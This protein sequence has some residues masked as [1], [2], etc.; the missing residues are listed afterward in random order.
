MPWTVSA[1]YTASVVGAPT[2]AYAPWAVFCCAG[3]LFTLV[4]AAA[5]EKMG[6]GLN[7]V[8]LRAA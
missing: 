4:L 5:F 1:V 7:R 2:T 6:F 3:T 8:E